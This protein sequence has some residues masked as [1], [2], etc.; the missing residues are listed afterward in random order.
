[1]FAR[2]QGASQHRFSVRAL[3][4]RLGCVEGSYYCKMTM[5]VRCCCL[6]VVVVVV[7]AVV[8]TRGRS[9]NWYVKL[10]QSLLVRYDMISYI[11]MED[12]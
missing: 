9:D 4:H 10:G 7:V 11:P 2:L 8:G 5:A 6:L 3:H 12:V 1:M